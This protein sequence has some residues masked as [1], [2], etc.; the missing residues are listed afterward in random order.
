MTSPVAGIDPHQDSFTVG[1]V[2]PNGVE[3]ANE[4]YPNSAVG[5]T[6]AIDTMTTHRVERVGVEFGSRAPMLEVAGGDEPTVEPRI[7]HRGRAIART[8]QES[9]PHLPRALQ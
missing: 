5:Y 8:D 6:D 4:S 1:I 3:I 2:D 7:L 9:A